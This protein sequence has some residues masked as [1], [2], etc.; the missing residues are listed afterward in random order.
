MNYPFLTSKERDNETGLDYFEARYFGSA[1]GR[2]TS[3]DPL[4]GHTED[5]QTLNRY[6]YVRNSPL[7]FTD[8]SGMDFYLQCEGKSSTCQGGRVGT[9]DKD[10]HFNATIISND[11]KG[12]LV[13][14]AG[15]SY[16][17]KI[18]GQGVSFNGAGSKE[19]VSGVFL[20]GTNATTIQ[21][22]GDLTGFTFNFTSSNLDVNQTAKGTFTFNG[23]AA[24]AAKSLERAGYTNDPRDAINIY[25]PS[26]DEY[27][28][29][30]YRSAGEGQTAANSGHFTLHEP[31][32]TTRH[33]YLI[34]AGPGGA[35]T[36][37]TPKG[38]VPVSGEVH[39][40]EHN[41]WTGGLF[42]HSKELTRP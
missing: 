32:T 14:Q 37:K 22:T 13:D 24:E 5:P 18:T 2:F 33:I 19:Y 17:A 8:P 9:T 21:G 6:T 12:N 20:N 10:G 23:T 31:V 3:P 29:I 41:P 4:G 16:T 40:G 1:Q 30:E 35:A 15:N 38:T 39:F 27:K 26:T 11:S 34:G 7:V 42:G 28:A 36:F 25:H